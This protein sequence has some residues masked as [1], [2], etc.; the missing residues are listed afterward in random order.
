MAYTSGNA[1]IQSPVAVMNGQIASSI[2]SLGDVTERL[3]KLASTM[4]DRLSPILRPEG[5]DTIASGETEQVL[6]PL[7]STLIAMV[8]RLDHVSGLIENILDRQQL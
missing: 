7:A 2:M 4:T 6:A 8:N 1:N 5:R 3:E